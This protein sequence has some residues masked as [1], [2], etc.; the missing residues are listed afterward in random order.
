MA[1]CAFSASLGSK[2][3]IIFSTV[4]GS[5]TLG[6]SVIASFQDRAHRPSRWLR[7]NSFQNS[8]KFGG[9]FPDAF[10]SLLLLLQVLFADPQERLFLETLDLLPHESF[11]FIADFLDPR[12]IHNS[13]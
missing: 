1:I 4:P 7:R 13:R 6:F 10:Q 3:L 8:E 2:G 11:E 9:Q 5:V 12:T